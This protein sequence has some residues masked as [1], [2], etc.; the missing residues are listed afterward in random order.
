MQ[1][2]QN[3]L[4]ARLLGCFVRLLICI[5]IEPIH[6]LQTSGYSNQVL[7]FNKKLKDI[8]RSKSFEIILLG[9]LLICIFA[10]PILI[11]IF[12][13]PIHHLQAPAET[14]WTIQIW[15]GSSDNDEQLKDQLRSISLKSRVNFQSKRSQSEFSLRIQLVKSFS[16]AESGDSHFLLSYLDKKLNFEDIP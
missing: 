15:F 7:K 11:C 16:H 12:I 4:Q 1:Q 10:E 13:E 5:F 8:F 3:H 14:S 2:L 6:H 9:C